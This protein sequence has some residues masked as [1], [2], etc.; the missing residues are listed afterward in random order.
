MPIQPFTSW[1]M[2]LSG[3]LPTTKLGYEWIVTWVDCTSK[4]IVAAPAHSD[5]TSAEDIAALTFG[6]QL[7]VWVA[8]DFDHGQ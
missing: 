5:R 4:T 7:Q 1:A 6:D 2:D 3:P 8:V